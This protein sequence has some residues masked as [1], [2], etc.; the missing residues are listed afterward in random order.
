MNFEQTHVEL[1]R[2]GRILLRQ[3]RPDDGPLFMEFLEHVTPQD[4]RLRFFALVNPHDDDFIFRLTHPDSGC[5]IVLV[6]LDEQTN[7]ILGVGRLHRISGGTAAEYA[8]L[9][10]SALKGKGLG[11]ALMQSLIEQARAAGLR[12]IQ[13]LILYEN[14]RMLQMCRELGFSIKS[15]EDDPNVLLAKLALPAAREPRSSAVAT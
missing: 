13:G 4:L 2:L 15:S 3:V 7:Q 12:N 6:A 11:W 1:P 8:V 14:E 10:R 5:V 9:V